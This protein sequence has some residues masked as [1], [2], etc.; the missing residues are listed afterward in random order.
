[1][2]IASY[3][4][5]IVG[6]GSSGCVLANRLSGDGRFRVLLI[7]SGGRDR[8][9]WIQIP[10]GVVFLLQNLR[11]VWT[12]PTR[13]TPSFGNRSI[14]LLQ[15]KTLGGSSAV[16]GMMYVRG[17]RQDYDYWRDLG[18]EG[19]SWD[20]VLPY[21]KRSENLTSGGSDEVHGRSGEMRVSWV[22]DLHSSSKA[23]M[24][25]AQQAGMPFNEDVND[26]NQDGVGYLLGTIYKGRRQSTAKAFL[27]PIK[28]RRNLTVLRNATVLRVVTEGQRAVGVEVQ[29]KNESRQLIRCNHEVVLCAGA[30]GTPFILQHS[31]IGDSDHLKSVGIEPV[32]NLPQVG[33]N[34]Q[35]HLFGHLKYRVKRRDDSRNGL[36]L[37]T[38][39]MAKE[40]LK[41][42]LTGRGAMNTTSSQVVGFFKSDESMERSDLQLAMRPFT[43]SVQDNGSIGVDSVPAITASAIQTRPFSRG[44]VK[45][46]SSD[47]S[48]RGMID[49]NYLSDP[50]DVKALSKGI[51]RIR[52]I[53]SQRSMADIISHELEPGPECTS[54]EQLD[55]YLRDNA[56]TVYHPVGTCRMGVDSDAVVNPQLKLNGIEGL[57]VADAS[58]MPVITSGNTNAPAIMI[59]EKASDLILND[60]QLSSAR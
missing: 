35:D 4:F 28:S 30:L 1:M 55:G 54:T 5:I 11:Y 3:D 41:W 58:I 37:S 12:N 60:Y 39:G 43:F 17:Q 16:N 51:E 20:D 57:R 56:A 46:T 13:A 23:F 36:L 44:E 24:L 10:A 27:H 47:P 14:G 53:M 40:A 49:S 48:D 45:I 21:F 25:A 31:G 42:L 50:R 52:Q 15:G 8:N 38:V 19:W 6:A 22:D 33:K 26:G 7:E 59:G 29:V 18:C 34:L 2:S 9:P 32:I